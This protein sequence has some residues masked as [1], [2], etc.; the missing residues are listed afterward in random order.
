MKR[1]LMA[2]ASAAMIGLTAIALPSK[3]EANGWWIA[4]AVI[5]G[6]ALAVIASDAYAYQHMS[7][8]EG[9]ADMPFCTANVRL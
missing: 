6:L 5:G 7:A 9:K 2:V 1:K 4:G 3:A 8:F